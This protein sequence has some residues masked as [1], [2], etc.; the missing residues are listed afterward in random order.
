MPVQFDVLPD[1]ATELRTLLT[2]SGVD[3]TEREHQICFRFASRGCQWQTV[4]QSQENLVL[5]Y[6]VHPARVTHPDRALE[7]CSELNRRVVRGSF[8]LQEERIVFRTSVQLTE[9]FEAQ[10]Q[11]AD[12][13]EYNAA[14]L[15]TFW[16]RLAA[17]AEGLVL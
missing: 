15:S 10:T 17:G 16:E 3:F 5:I 4:C 1:G 12:A 14:A 11:I 7:V 2:R 13:L 6:G 9:R 8:F